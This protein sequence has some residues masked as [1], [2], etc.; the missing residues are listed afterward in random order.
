MFREGQRIILAAPIAFPLLS[1][2][3]NSCMRL[4]LGVSRCLC[5][6]TTAGAQRSQKSFLF[7]DAVPCK[8]QLLPR[9]RTRRHLAVWALTCPGSSAALAPHLPGRIVCCSSCRKGRPFS[10]SGRSAGQRVGEKGKKKGS[11]PPRRAVDRGAQ[12]RQA[13]EV[14]EGPQE[15]FSLSSTVQPQV[16]AA[17]TP[18]FSL[19]SCPWLFA[20]CALGSEFS[21]RTLG[22]K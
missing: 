13:G 7:G 15:M 8:C 11:A 18:F 19:P 3:Q 22:K 10:V 17:F 20:N 6:S 12:F 16:S 9:E 14:A 2:S 4:L 5:L 1:L 21:E